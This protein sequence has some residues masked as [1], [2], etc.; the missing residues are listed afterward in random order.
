MPPDGCV[1]GK[2]R[3]LRKGNGQMKE[4]PEL[5]VDMV[6]LRQLIFQSVMATHQSTVTFR[7]TKWLKLQQFNI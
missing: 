6:E 7:L 4:G 3:V 1:P 5:N 2:F